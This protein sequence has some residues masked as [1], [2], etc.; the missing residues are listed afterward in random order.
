LPSSRGAALAH[1]L[2]SLFVHDRAAPGGGDEI[3]TDVQRL[4]RTLVYHGRIIDLLVDDVATP[5]GTRTVREI[6]HHPGGA[7]AVPLFDDGRVI[8][9]QQLRYPLGARILELPAGKLALG[10]NPRDAAARELEE[11]TGWTAGR[12]EP[13]TSIYTS[14]GFCDEVLHLFVA[15]DLTPVP[16]GPR[17]DEG[18]LTMAV[19]IV[20]LAEA[21]AMVRRGEIRDAKTIIGLLLTE[22]QA[23][24]GR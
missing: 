1:E 13:L 6:V 20:P 11:E 23:G 18:E 7:V 21:C 10:E 19:R 16:G 15:R 4:S 22:R 14:P 8:L 9:V 3:M 24:G 17:R 2:T 5:S 12:W